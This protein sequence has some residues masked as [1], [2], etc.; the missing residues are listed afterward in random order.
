MAPACYQ[1]KTNGFSDRVQANGKNIPTEALL[2]KKMLLLEGES[3]QA[4]GF[5]DNDGQRSQDC[6]VFHDTKTLSAHIAGK[7]ATQEGEPIVI[8]DTQSNTSIA[9]TA[10]DQF[11]AALLRLQ[12]GLDVS[13]QRLDSIEAKVENLTRQQRQQSK[14]NS[15][16]IKKASTWTKALLGDGRLG[17]LLYLSWPLFVFVAMKALERRSLMKKLN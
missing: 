15:S 16:G 9:Q 6:D 11:A 5:G 1:P 12:S 13:K 8:F 2:N 14:P 3:Q 17:T 10:K 7:R 4:N